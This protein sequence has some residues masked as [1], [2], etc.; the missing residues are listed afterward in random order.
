[1]RKTLF[2]PLLL[3][4]SAC[5]A[6][7]EEQAADAR[8]A[9]AA[10][11]YAK[12][13]I[14]AASA[15][16][17][18]PGNKDLLLLQ[19]QTLL[20]L[21]DG[22]GAGAALQKLAEV[23]GVPSQAEL[24]A[25]AALLRNAPQ[26]ARDA[27]GRATSSEA[28]RLRGLVAIQ[29]GD[30][31]AAAGFFAKAVAVGDNARAYADMA[32]L[33]LMERDIAGASDL[34][35]KAAALAPQ[36]IDTLLIQGQI[37]LVRGDLKAALDT[38]SLAAKR[39]PTS[40]AAL[41]GQAA[42]LGDLGRFK[43]MLTVADK[44]AELAPRNLQVAY[45]RA[46]AGVAMQNWE[47][48]RSI[49]QPLEAELPAVDPL[50]VLY[51]QAL[52]KLDRSELA[53]AQLTPIARVQPGNR[54]VALLLAEARL[55]SND[56]KGAMA[57][58]QAIAD[59]VQ[60][61]PEEL[62]AMAR[63]AKVAGDPR[64]ADYERRAKSPL[65]QV[66][67]AD[68]AEADA[69]IQRGDWAKAAIAYDRILASTKGGN[70]LVLNNMAY[71]QSMLGNHDKARSFADQALRRAPD[72]ASVLDTAGWVRFRAGQDLENAKR[73]LRRAAEQAPQNKTIQMHLAE[74]TRTGS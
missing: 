44:A 46:R 17:A 30:T 2:L 57:A 1:M 16:E 37:A 54:K 21:G 65:L 73:L 52:V 18:M 70:V 5:S 10:N 14:L 34:A 29:D 6:S 62:A 66:V 24:T 60:A 40:L 35:Q 27:L 12:A 72:N 11:D 39:Y 59:S 19:A 8:A 43:D 71:A 25:E 63:A 22:A 41:N 20:A 42:A 64:A 31:G 61:R 4:I 38:Y 32:R 47:L 33:R 49:V 15:L 55:A 51:A 67:G 9:F 48:V 3:A 68:L 13:R 53:A 69:A 36:K 26:V 7:P 56:P 45:L 74:A 23:G 50:R 28:D 58:L